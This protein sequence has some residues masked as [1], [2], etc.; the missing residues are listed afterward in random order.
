MEKQDKNVIVQ[1]GMVED[2]RESSSPG[3]QEKGTVEEQTEEAR[4]RG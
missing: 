4:T 1:L 2:I 3:R